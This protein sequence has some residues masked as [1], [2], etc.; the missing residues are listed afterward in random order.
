M[1]NE[2]AIVALVVRI[3][4]PVVKPGAEMLRDYPDGISVEF[5]GDRTA[6]LSP[7]DLAAG[8][9]EILDDLRKMDAPAYVEVDA[10]SNEIT[11]LLIPL[12][13]KVANFFE[14]AA[15]EIAV[16]LEISHARHVLKRG[17][18]DFD[19]FLKTLRAAQEEDAWLI[20]TETDDHEIIDARR[21]PH[22]LAPPVRRKE[23]R[24]LFR[25]LLD[26][27]DRLL[28]CL[29][30]V[31]EQKAREMF[32]LVSIQTCDPLAVPPPCIPFL[33][34]DDGCWGRA[35]EMCR[36]MI[37]AGVTPKKVWIYGSLHAAT[38]NNPNCS[39]S[40][41]W[42]VAPTLCV[43]RHFCRGEDVVIDP[44]LFTEPVSKPTW[45]GVQGDA[46]AQ[47]VDSNASVFYRSFNGNT[48]T[49]PNYV[50]TGQVL[51]TYRLMLKNRSLQFGPPPYAQCP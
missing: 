48:Q 11:R 36:L 41:G 20:V 38:K 17:N 49:D 40:W 21:P 33:Y 31:S 14:S 15:E 27:F 30:C 28:K 12:V 25:L 34:P 29:R 43:R 10:D 2:N 35:H 1:P 7:S 45:T 42:H 37:A 39:V 23:P 22:E 19:E 50:Q 44:A 16:E 24:G 9:L 6:R 13:V 46:N 47:L 8:I 32:D 26:C 4:P 51:A 3:D 5:E 18:P